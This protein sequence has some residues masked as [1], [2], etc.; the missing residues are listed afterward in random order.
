MKTI[1]SITT[2]VLFVV[3]LISGKTYAQAISVSLAWTKKANPYNNS[4]NSV[5]FRADGQK[6]LSGTNCHPAS[7]RMFDVT[8]SDLV[9]DY[10]VGSH[11]MCIM[12]VTF[13][14]NTNYIAAIEEFGNI[15]IFDNTG[16]TPVII[17]TIHTAT[18]YAFCTA[19]SPSNDKVAAG[20]SG[21]RL[22]IF[23]LPGGTLSNNIAA[24]TGWVTAVA[25]SPNGNKIVTGGSDDKVKIWTKTGTLLFTCLGHTGDI[26][27]VKVSPDSNY[28]ISSSKD[29]TIKI[30]DM[31]TGTLVRTITGH[32]KSV[33]SIDISPDGTKIVSASSD[34]S[35][36]IWDFDGNLILTFDT[37]NSCVVNAVAWSNSGDKI[38]TGNEK[39][40]I[41]VWNVNTSSSIMNYNTHKNSLQIF[42][43]PAQNT[44]TINIPQTKTISRLCLYNTLGQLCK[45]Y[46]CTNQT[47][48]HVDSTNLENGMYFIILRNDENTDTYTGK[49][50]INR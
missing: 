35:C 7:I 20:C 5:A 4:I 47:L 42:P 17:D 30:W 48:L 38:V 39:S 1:K 45:E 16:S 49:V 24:H 15:F 11:Y 3:L 2:A 46:T 9:W 10:D 14:A 41:S 26:T 31:N 13:S 44:F 19:I 27:S 21:G 6:V 36:K 32:T 12:G 25:Y 43:N 28:V 37:G 8:T 33:N 50:L 23:N 34:S 40:D 22:K 29:K 18:S